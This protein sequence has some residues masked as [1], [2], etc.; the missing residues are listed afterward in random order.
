M[1]A[2]LPDG[3]VPLRAIIEAQ[4]PATTGMLIVLLAVG[5]LIPIPG[6]AA[7]LGLGI[8]S[9]S[10]HIYLGRDGVPLPGRLT[11]LPLTQSGARRLLNALA[12]ID[13]VAGRWTRK[14]ATGFARTRGNRPVAAAV[15]I[16]ACL[17]ILP[18]PLGNWPAALSLIALGLGLAR[19]DGF[20]V[21][22]GGVLGVFA[23]AV[24]VAIAAAIWR[25]VGVLLPT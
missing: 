14:R 19:R 6:I 12:A 3:P 20:A 25:L 11:A 23:L 21:L 15:G 18:L 7:V 16:M 5:C 2:R 10:M 9:L 8:A 4:G 24:N 22:I 1:A 17:I 13:G